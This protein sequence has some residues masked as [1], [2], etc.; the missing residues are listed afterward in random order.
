[1]ADLGMHIRGGA[2]HAKRGGGSAVLNRGP[3][4]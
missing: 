4:G 3:I 2:E 1:M